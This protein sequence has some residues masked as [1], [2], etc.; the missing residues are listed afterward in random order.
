MKKI[1]FFFSL[2]L[3]L[4]GCMRFRAA[5]RIKS[6]RIQSIAILP[7]DMVMSGRI[8]ARM[9]PEE[10]QKRVDDGK[11]FMQQALYSEL[12]R[13][14]D[15]R[16]RRYSMVEF[17]GIDKTKQLLHQNNISDSACQSLDAAYLAKILGVDAL[18]RARVSKVQIMSNE[19]GFG[20]DMAGGVLRSIG[21]NPPVPIPNARTGDVYIS[22]SLLTSD[23]P[24][25]ATN[26]ANGI[27]W[28]LPVEAIMQHNARALV[29][30]LRL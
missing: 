15:L 19:A 3:L 24:I 17:Q 21:V 16:R 28:N 20:L 9:S 13:S 14:A 26:F 25:W 8:P 7:V 30:R 11:R 6:Y 10:Y 1:I 4:S 23:G 5:Q 22:C 12:V 18:L 2:L 27:D 29:R